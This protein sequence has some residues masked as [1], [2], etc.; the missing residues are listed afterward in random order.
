MLNDRSSRAAQTG[1]DDPR[2]RSLEAWF[3]LMPAEDK[4]LID[5]MAGR[6]FWHGDDFDCDSML[7]ALPAHPLLAR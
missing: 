4:A 3:A 1:A 7:L 2:L 5:A 6:N